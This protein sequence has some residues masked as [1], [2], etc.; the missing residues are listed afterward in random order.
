MWPDY[1]HQSHWVA[2][3]FRR[4]VQDYHRYFIDENSNNLMKTRKTI[5]IALNK[6]SLLGSYLYAQPS[7]KKLWKPLIC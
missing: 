6:K 5:N 3:E 7:E 1:K 4:A 2:S